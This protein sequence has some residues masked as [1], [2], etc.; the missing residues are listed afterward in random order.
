MDLLISVGTALVALLICLQVTVLLLWIERKG[1][2]LIQ[3]RVGANRANL[4][5]G[6]LPFNLGI[7]NT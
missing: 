6:L 3:D 5:G 4:F 2:A 1:S 7:V